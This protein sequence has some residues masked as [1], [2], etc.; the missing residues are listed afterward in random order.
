M[1]KMKKK[2]FTAQKGNKACMNIDVA[3]FD[4]LRFSL[5]LSGSVNVVKRW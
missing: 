2:I 4:R 5:L 3:T 1:G